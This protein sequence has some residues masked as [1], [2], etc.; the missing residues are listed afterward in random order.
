MYELFLLYWKIVKASFFG[1]FDKNN[2]KAEEI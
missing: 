1:E 2:L